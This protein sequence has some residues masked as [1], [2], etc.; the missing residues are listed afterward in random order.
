MSVLCAEL[1]LSVL[2]LA[3]SF[4]KADPVEWKLGITLTPY[5]QNEDKTR[6]RTPK[7]PV[8]ITKL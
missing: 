1:I 4:E 6:P 7:V 3:F 5:V 2:L 8:R